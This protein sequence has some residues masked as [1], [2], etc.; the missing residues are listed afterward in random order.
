MKKIFINVGPPKT[1]TSA[2]QNWAQ[3]NRDFLRLIGVFY[4]SHSLDR[5]GVSSGNVY[6]LFDR[7]DGELLF[8]QIKWQKL[9]RNFES[10]NAGILLLSSEFFFLNIDKLHEHIPDASF[11]VYVRSPLD[12]RES[13]YNQA[14]KRHSE[15]KIFPH[16]QGVSK[17]TISKIV[18]GLDKI[19]Q[20]KFRVRMYHSD[21]FE[22]GN[23]VSDLLLS[24]GV[25]YDSPIKLTKSVNNSYQF[26]ALEFKRWINQFSLNSLEFRLDQVIQA[27]DSGTA[28]YSL[29]PPDVF[30]R[31]KNQCLVI[32]ADFNKN[33]HVPKSGDLL[34]KTRS[35]Q[36]KPYRKQ[37]LNDAEFLSVVNF[38]RSKDEGLLMNLFEEI[39]SKSTA[40]QRQ[41]KFYKLLQKS[42]R[43]KIDLKYLISK[44]FLKVKAKLKRKN[45]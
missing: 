30:I 28:V 41:D 10:S 37:E 1:G 14:V 2:I 34:S 22:G 16:N 6:S 17:G 4:P 7:N 35:T 24:M 31:M 33:H 8:S 44:T 32:L 38:I 21:I 15:T 18:E 29:I 25:A 9:Y 42:Y 23:I 45:I 43:K 12:F 19:G 39:S 27:F 3:S 11:I 13:S 20:K 5:N 40:V 36:Q 26:E